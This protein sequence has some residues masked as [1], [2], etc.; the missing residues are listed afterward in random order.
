[1]SLISHLQELKKKH[2]SLSDAVEEAQRAPSLD[3]IYIASLKKQKLRLKEEIA[4]LSP[5]TVH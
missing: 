5:Q 3:N 1:M 2:Q 4:R